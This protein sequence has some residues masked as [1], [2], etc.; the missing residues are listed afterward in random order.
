MSVFKCRHFSYF[1]NAA[2]K[3]DSY[4]RWQ[5]Y[6]NAIRS[7]HQERKLEHKG[8]MILL[9]E[10]SN[11]EFNSDDVAFDCFHLNKRG[12]EKNSCIYF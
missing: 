11:I 6:N 1:C 5:D 8:D 4:Q 10:I 2:Y 7:I 12:T 9:D 3:E